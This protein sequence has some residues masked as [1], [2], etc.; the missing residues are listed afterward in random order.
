MLRKNIWRL[1]IAARQTKSACAD[2]I[3]PAEAGFVCVAPD[4]QSVGDLQI[5]D[6]PIKYVSVDTGNKHCY[7][8]KI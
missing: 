7:K 6:A 1:E 4:F 5:Q 2:S 3:E 8:D